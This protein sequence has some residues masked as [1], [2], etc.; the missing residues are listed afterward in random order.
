M[1]LKL[2]FQMTLK[3][4]PALLV[5]LAKLDKIF[6]IILKPMQIVG[7]F[8]FLTITYFLG[9]GLS[10]LWYRFTEGRRKDSA[11]AGSYWVPL[12]ASEKKRENW[13]RPF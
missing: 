8:V 7:N 2:I 4:P 13:L 11:A 12:P 3:I 10:A 1:Q 9:V 5:F 6:R